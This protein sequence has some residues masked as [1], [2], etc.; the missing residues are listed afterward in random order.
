MEESQQAPA[1]RRPRRV[2]KRLLTV[3]IAGV[4]MVVATA[5]ARAD[6]MHLW[7][8]TGPQH[9]STASAKVA[10]HA[11][12]SSTDA[13]DGRVSERDNTWG[14]MGTYDGKVI[15]LPREVAPPNGSRVTSI[16]RGSGVLVFTCTAGVFQPT[17][18]VQNLFSLKGNPVGIHF[19]PPSWA[20]SK[21]GSRVDA[22][23]VKVVRAKKTAPLVL[24]RA[25][26]V[27]G[28][29]GL[30]G[31]TAFV[32]QLPLTGGVAPTTCTV[33]GKRIAV[34]FQSLYI[35]FRS[36]VTTKLPTVTTPAPAGTTLYGTH[37]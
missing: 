19:G 17:E 18:P 4:V 37:W 34:P 27:H 33:P 24:F 11:L 22:V 28:G 29:L 35:F 25:I 2:A 26:N 3:G 1:P 23:P 21:D 12:V 31:R 7:S 13:D 14:N 30:F 32:V 9:A 10:S 15:I 6:A 20:S 16:L 5:V 8:G 36:T